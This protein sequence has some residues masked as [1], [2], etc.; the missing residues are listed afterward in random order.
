[1]KKIFLIF[2]LTMSMQPTYAASCVNPELIL[3]CGD[4]TFL[5][6]EKGIEILRG[7][8]D[9]FFSMDGIFAVTGGLSNQNHPG[10]VIT[11]SFENESNLENVN[12]V[13]PNGI[14]YKGYK[15]EFETGKIP[16]PI[17]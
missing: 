14:E 5:C 4:G 2:A 11:A 7:I 1:M 16:H 13:F 3:D 9:I 6:E 12:K 17:P 15:V 8:S 10:C